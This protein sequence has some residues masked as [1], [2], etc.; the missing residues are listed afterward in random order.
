MEGFL[1]EAGVGDDSLFEHIKSFNVSDNIDESPTLLQRP[2][3]KVFGKECNQNRNVGFFSDESSGYSYSRQVMVSQKLTPQLKACLEAINSRYGTNFNGILINHYVDG[4]NYIGKHR[5]DEQGLDTK[6]NAVGSISF[7]A[8]RKFR[9]RGN[10]G[11]IV[12][13][14]DTEHGMFMMM[15]GDFQKNYTHEIP[16]Q[17]KITNPRW[18]LTFR[19]HSM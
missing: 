7:G 1:T 9:I 16:I 6:R 8:Q 12:R 11:K 3:I 18:S 14:V 15:F 10:D 5:D 19:H 17:K 13:D 2:R 4:T